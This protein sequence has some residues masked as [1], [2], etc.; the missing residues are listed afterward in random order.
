[1]LIRYSDYEVCVRDEGLDALT[2]WRGGGWAARR[3][4]GTT[5]GTGRAMGQLQ[6]SMMM[7]RRH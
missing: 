4:W 5:V 2:V 6:G 1:M 7:T 3:W